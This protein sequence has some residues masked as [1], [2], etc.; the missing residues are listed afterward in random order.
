MF[1]ERITVLD[2]SRVL[3]GPLAGSILAD[4]GAEVIKVEK[5][6]TGDE[7][8]GWGPP[9]A[10]G[11]AAYYMSAN[12]GKKSITLDL[13]KGK[14]VLHKLI[15]KSDILIHNFLP[16]TQEKLGISYEQVKKI[17]PDIIWV[18]IS[19]FG[20]FSNRP[21][22]DIIIQAMSGLMSITG[23][24]EDEP[25]KVGV[26]IT[27]VLTAYT[28]V[29]ATI[30]AL[31]RRE[32]EGKGARIDVSLMDTSLF[33]LVNIAY[34]YLIG[35]LIPQRMGNQHPNI[36]PY[37]LFRASDGYLIIGI[38]ND[39]Q[40]K[41]FVDFLNVKALKDSKFATNR[42][43]LKNREELIPLI[44]REIERKPMKF[45][46]EN[47][48]KLNIPCGPVLNVAESIENFGVK[49]GLIT[50]K[51]HPTAGSIR[52]MR[53]PGIYDGKRAPIKNHPPLLGENTREILTWLGYNE[54]EIEQMKK[55][56]IT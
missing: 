56:G 23:K 17:K 32:K 38:G 47:L 5:P 1:L 33:S 45:W 27:D 28:A 14:D 7:T 20:P 44:Q 19:G 34:N 41:K 18:S 16:A 2:L 22:Y 48:E 55:E 46:L 42:D 15:N 21:G 35:G 52:I 10:G 36:V 30:A 25:M 12:R 31:Y 40:W 9:F 53:N 50:E 37:Q 49:S 8:R 3:A 6:G 39:S 43:R 4:L 13:I 26:A 11:E 24:P 54:K 51:N 29:Y